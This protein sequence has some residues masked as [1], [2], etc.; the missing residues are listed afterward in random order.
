MEGVLSGALVGWTRGETEK[1]DPDLI[2][3]LRRET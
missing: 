2:N 1:Q 3:F